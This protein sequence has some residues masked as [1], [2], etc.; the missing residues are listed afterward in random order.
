MI[1]MDEKTLSQ[2]LSSKGTTK[3]QSSPGEDDSA[4]LCTGSNTFKIKMSETSNQLMVLNGS[5]IVCTKTVFIEVTTSKAKYQQVLNFL[6]EQTA[7]C[8]KTQIL[9][10]CQIS[11]AE[12]EGML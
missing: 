9:E 10:S 4:V 7:R 6:S 11:E 1:E 3:I 12:F 8:S 5:D 2:I